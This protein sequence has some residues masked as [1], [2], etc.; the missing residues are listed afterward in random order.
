MITVLLPPGRLAA[1]DVVSLDPAE[2]HHL[3]VRRAG[4]VVP[5][6]LRDGQGLLGAGVVRS[7]R[8]AVQ[9]VVER[10]EQ[11]ARPLPLRLAVA[12]GDRDRFAWLVEKATELGVTELVPVETDRTAAVASRIREGQLGRLR[13]R[14]L[15]AIKQCGA[16]WAPVVHPARPLAEFLAEA[17]HGDRWLADRSGQPPGSG[18]GV[19]PVTV[20][21]GPEGG[22]SDQETQSARAAGFRPLRLAEH[23]LRFET[24]AVAG[25]P[26]AGGAR[27]AQPGGL[28]G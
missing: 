25:G 20:L 14:A 8:G 13:R 9:V 5:V 17:L 11:V 7:E 4:E 26:R 21:V 18:F 27:V 1:G 6:Q 12:A 23:V 28:H 19:G 3:R 2:I 24:A 10:A 15:E 16:P 22:L